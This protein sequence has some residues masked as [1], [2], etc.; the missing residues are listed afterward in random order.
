LRTASYKVFQKY[1]YGLEGM[2]GEGR[3][4]YSPR[5][6]APTVGPTAD[7]VTNK[8]KDPNAGTDANGCPSPRPSSLVNINGLTIDVS[9]PR[10]EFLGFLFGLQSNTREIS[11]CFIMGIDV[12]DQNEQI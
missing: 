12:L 11:N 2:F 9:D 8:N 5:L 10:A 6:G 7:P 3:A 1:G 4:K